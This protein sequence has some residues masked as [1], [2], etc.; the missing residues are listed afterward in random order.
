MSDVFGMNFLKQ[1]A[2]Y[3]GPT[4]ETGD[5]GQELYNDPIEIRCRWDDRPTAFIDSM[6]NEAVSKA[7]VMVDRD[8]TI[9][10]ILWQGRLSQVTSETDPFLNSNAWR[11]RQ[12]G[13]TPDTKTKKFFRIAYL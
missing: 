6:G 8:L 1:Y 3:W 11:I 10:G 2:V 7:E 13:K 12:F 5:A 9:L 4:G